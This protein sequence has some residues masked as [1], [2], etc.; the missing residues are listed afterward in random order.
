M[1]DQDTVT[2]G[3]DYKGL[4]RD[5]LIAA[6]SDAIEARYMP[7][8]Q[9]RKILLGMLKV[10]KPSQKRLTVEGGKKKMLPK[11]NLIELKAYAQSVLS[12]L[13]PDE[14]GACSRPPGGVCLPQ[15]CTLLV[16][17]FTERL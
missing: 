8:A 2:G 5:Q 12:S 17:R 6:A 9:A 16:R 15:V 13:A 10:V 4:T 14:A 7:A 3:F 1:T 11:A